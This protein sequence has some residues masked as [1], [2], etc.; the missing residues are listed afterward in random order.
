MQVKTGK[1]EKN[2]KEIIRRLRIQNKK[3]LEQVAS[4]KDKLKRRGFSLRLRN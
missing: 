1:Q 4:L 3:L 2:S